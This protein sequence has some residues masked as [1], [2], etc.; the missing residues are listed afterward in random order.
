MHVLLIGAGSMG[1]NHAMCYSQMKG[2]TLAGIVELS[3]EKG[4]ELAARVGTK[5]FPSLE[6]ALSH[7]DNVDVVDVCLPT[8]LH[9]EYVM[10]AA[11]AGKH[12]ICEKPL[13]GTLENAREMIDYCKE[14]GVRLFVGHVLRFFHEYEQAKKLLDAGAIGPVAVA[15]TSRGGGF[16]M[17]WNNWYNDFSSSG[18]LTLDLII[19]DFD[20][21]RWYFGEVER[22][23]ARGLY[24]K[25]PDKLDYSLVTLRFKNGTIAHVEGSWAHDGFAMKFE[26]A[27]KTG[28]IDYDSTRDKPIVAVSRA[29]KQGFIGV[30]VPES[31]VKESPYYKELKHFLACIAN[32]TESRMTAEDAYKA[33]EIALAAIESMKSGKP[34]KLGAE[35]AISIQ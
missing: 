33:L 1:G 19:H 6:E 29:D 7:L 25:D 11:D 13:S 35:S 28:V 17:G 15:R 21:L 16:P 26:L 18:G 4:E 30:A 32:N 5:A 8:F 14:K 31:P 34:V 9:K 2:I 24:P 10:K 12:V 20:I 22:V 3:Q 27:G 23:Y